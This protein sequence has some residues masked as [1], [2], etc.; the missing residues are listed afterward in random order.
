M[1][2]AQ[3]NC[4]QTRSTG[5]GISP[6]LSRCKDG[7]RGVVMTGVDISGGVMLRINMTRK[8]PTEGCMTVAGSMLSRSRSFR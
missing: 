6:G 1:G 2:L 5:V 4:G 8:V 7:G 3:C